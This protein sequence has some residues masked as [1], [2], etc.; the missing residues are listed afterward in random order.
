MPQVNFWAS[1]DW[2]AALEELSLDNRSEYIR[3]AVAM[4][5]LRD[6]D[7]VL[8][9]SRPHGVR[10]DAMPTGW[11]SRLYRDRYQLVAIWNRDGFQFIPLHE[12]DLVRTGRVYGTLRAETPEPCE[13]T[14]L[15]IPRDTSPDKVSAQLH[16][17]YITWLSEQD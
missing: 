16:L 4:R 15:D 11:K 6:F 3:E 13:I 7:K 17:D 8:P 9:A 12:F 14:V 10:L 2:K 5:V 1:D